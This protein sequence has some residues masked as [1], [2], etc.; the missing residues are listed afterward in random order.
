VK[1]TEHRPRRHY[2]PGSIQDRQWGELRE[3]V[4]AIGTERD[5]RSRLA[6]IP[7]GRYWELMSAYWTPVPDYVELNRVRKVLLPSLA[8]WVRRNVPYLDELH[9]LEKSVR[10]VVKLPSG[11]RVV[12]TV[13]VVE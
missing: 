8:S 1:D 11:K 4:D 9:E 5:R 3:A 2:S 6:D 13:S 12:R 10:F 7:A